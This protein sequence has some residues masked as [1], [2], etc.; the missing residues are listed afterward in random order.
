MCFQPH[1]HARTEAFF[2]EFVEALSQADGLVVPEI[3]RVEGRTEQ[4]IV[5]S[6]GL[7]KALQKKHPELSVHHAMTFD[8]AEEFLVR[9]V[10]QQPDCVIV[11]QG[12]GS[13]D[14][15]A[16]KMTNKPPRPLQNLHISRHCERSFIIE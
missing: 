16:R 9:L 6:L 7:V 10:E 8:E 13:I 5:S 1:Q 4:E 2:D 3:Y 15:L 14:E 11:I 12:A